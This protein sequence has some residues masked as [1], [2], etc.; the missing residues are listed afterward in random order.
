MKMTLIAVAAIAACSVVAMPTGDELAKATKEV[1]AAL[2]SQIAA[3]QSGSIS[4]GDLAVLMLRRSRRFRDAQRFA[5]LQMALEAAVRVSDVALTADILEKIAADT[6]DFGRKESGN[7]V[8]GALKNKGDAKKADKADAEIFGSTRF[9]PDLEIE[10]EKRAYKKSVSI[11]D[12]TAYTVALM[13][14]IS[15]TTFDVK[16]QTTLAEVVTFLN[17]ASRTHDRHAKLHTGWN[18]VKIVLKTAKGEP[19]PTVPEV[20]GKRYV[21]VYNAVEFI[22]K[23]TG[24]DFEVKDKTVVIFKKDGAAKK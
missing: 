7:L 5:C 6:K 21:N 4:D 12:R 2:E 24:Y 19:V 8:I 15:L 22:T 16:P 1:Q 14:H 18:G 10:L 9:I 3:Y 23:A 20:H 17:I 13:K 11:S